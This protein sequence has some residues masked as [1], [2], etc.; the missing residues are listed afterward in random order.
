MEEQNILLGDINVLNQ[1]RRDIKD[2]NGKKEKLALLQ[3][4]V[5]EIQKNIDTAEKALKDEI[6]TTLKSRRDAVS[7]GFDKSIESDQEKLKKILA[8]REKAKTKGV[9]E[10]INVET[11]SLR[12]DNAGLSEEIKQAFRQQKIPAFCRGR[13]FASLYMTS[14]IKDVMVVF[15]T[16]LFIFAVI[17][18]LV[19]YFVKDINPFIVCAIYM[20][21]ILISYIF[22]KIMYDVIKM[23]HLET[24]KAYKETKE[25]I[26]AN[27][28]KIKKIQRS[29]RKDKNEDMYGLDRYDSNIKQLRADIEQIEGKKAMALQEFDSAV[30]PNIIAQID[31]KDRARIEAMKNDYKV[32]NKVVLDMEN[33]VKE[34]RIYISANYDAYLGSEFTTTDKLEALSELMNTGA[35]ATIGQAISM[36]SEKK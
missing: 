11:S 4:E 15:I 9:K 8:E 3:V 30:K 21:L 1:I 35:A 2:H 18:M 32:K 34:Q 23:P 10:R 26:S 24:L 33:L 28:I 31:G 25:K 14:G 36:Y 12:E 16:L 19:C 22:N 13:W 17:P 20:V 27:K 29:I 7:A 6:D 5:K